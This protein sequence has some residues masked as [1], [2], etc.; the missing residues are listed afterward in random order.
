MSFWLFYFILL[1]CIPLYLS[2]LFLYISLCNFRCIFLQ[3][4]VWQMFL[5]LLQ[6][7]AIW[8]R[9]LCLSWFPGDDIHTGI[10]QFLSCNRLGQI[11]PVL[12]Q[13][14][15]ALQ[16]FKMLVNAVLYTIEMRYSEKV[17]LKKNLNMHILSA[18]GK[19]YN[20]LFINFLFH[21]PLYKPL[22]KPCGATLKRLHFI[23]LHVFV[24][25]IDFI[26]CRR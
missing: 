21:K 23:F 11:S 17:S 16:M 3:V 20:F 22:C 18:P 4:V 12:H 7:L 15:K 19:W 1:G 2:T 8:S 13:W 25:W 24:N 10:H 9:W 6:I 5:C 14:V 26:F